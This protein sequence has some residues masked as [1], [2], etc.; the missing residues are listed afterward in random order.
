MVLS[1]SSLKFLML[2]SQKYVGK[3]RIE[4]VLFTLVKSNL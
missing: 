1:V 4:I 2:G 3:L